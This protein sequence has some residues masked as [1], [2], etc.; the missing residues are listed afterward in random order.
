MSKDWTP[1]ELWAVNGFWKNTYGHGFSDM[2]ITFTDIQTGQEAPL[3][4]PEETKFKKRY[5]IFGLLYE[6]LYDLYEETDRE[7]I[8]SL[9]DAFAKV[10][11][12]LQ[13]ITNGEWQRDTQHTQ[14]EENIKL[15]FDGKLDTCFYYREGNDDLLAQ[16]I[17]EH[18]GIAPSEKDD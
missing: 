5:P 4:S 1:R 6:P 10:E 18:I 15:W 8:P 11:T 12:L 3:M 9:L 7:Y 14:F 2:K 16:A 13:T 17:R